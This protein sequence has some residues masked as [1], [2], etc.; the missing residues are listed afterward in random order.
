[1]EIEAHRYPAEVKESGEQPLDLPLVAL[2]TQFPPVL[3]PGL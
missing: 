2:A 3:R 1:M